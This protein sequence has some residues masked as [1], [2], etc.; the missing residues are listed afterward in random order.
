MSGGGSA[1]IDHCTV[2][3]N[4]ISA[5]YCANKDDKTTITNC[6]FAD[7]KR[8]L[9]YDGD[10]LNLNVKYTCLHSTDTD[11]DEAKSGSN[12]FRKDPKF[13]DSESGNYKLKSNS[14]CVNAAKDGSNMGC[15]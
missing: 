10:G 3:D 4:K 6:I 9:I 5:I 2:A 1:T 14:P 15:F 7:N 11:S 12:N 13:K 8:S